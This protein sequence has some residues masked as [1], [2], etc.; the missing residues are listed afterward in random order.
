MKKRG[1]ITVLGVTLVALVLVAQN[2]RQGDARVPA[3][4]SSELPPVI[5]PNTGLVGS[6]S[7]KEAAEPGLG[8]NKTTI[9]LDEKDRALIPTAPPDWAKDP[10]TKQKYLDSLQGYYEYRRQ[11]YNHR[12]GDFRWQHIST[13]VIFI[14]VLVLVFS[15]I[16]FAYVQFHVGLRARATQPSTEGEKSDLEISLKGLR[17]SSSI[18]GVIILVISLAFFY[19]YLVYVYPISDTF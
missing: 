14:S 19:L 11:A 8:A 13:I 15:G 7:S 3:P 17:V 5:D 1:P 16:Y 2:T 4:R 9:S 6:G 12:Q 18:L 10:A